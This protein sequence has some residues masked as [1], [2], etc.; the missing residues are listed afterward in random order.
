MQ[1][2]EYSISSCTSQCLNAQVDEAVEE[3]IIKHAS[4]RHP[5]IVP[6]KEVFLTSSHLA[7]VTER[8]HDKSIWELIKQ[9]GQVRQL[10]E[11][12]VMHSVDS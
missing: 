4:L 5:H 11:D 2:F 12:E 8:V 9:E 6:L 3:D 10:K 7:V 1:G